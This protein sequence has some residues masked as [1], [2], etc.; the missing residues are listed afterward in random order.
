M[1][2]VSVF[3]AVFGA[4]MGLIAASTQLSLADV[5]L[6]GSFLANKEC[7]AFQS[8][9]KGTNPD[10]AQVESGHSYQLLAKNA[11][12]ATHYRVRIENAS[13]PERWV[14]ADCGLL[15]EENAGSQGSGSPAGTST[16]NQT[17]FVLSLGWEPGFCESHNTKPECASERSD[18]FD[19][20]HFTLHGLW[21]QPRKREYCDVPLELIQADRRGNWQALP[22]VNLSKE[23][24][25]H[26]ALVMPGTR[27]L[28]DRH[29]WIRHGTCYGGD[30]ETYFRQALSLVD[31]I[32]GSAVQSLFAGNIGKE[33]SIGAIKDAFDSA[34]GAG[35]GDRVRL[36]C[37]R[38]GSRQLI[39]EITIGLGAQPGGATSL[40]DLIKASSPTD[41]GCPG[42]IVDA[43]GYQ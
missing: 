22:I 34:F 1:R 4:A 40:G 23:T 35:A 21:P 25:E 31:A 10:G 15:R 19:A 29:E 3:I 13:P 32:N 14:S 7:P 38:D 9:R 43:V 11:P 18:E 26:L 17:Q 8:F 41:P 16:E 42:G 37:K 5:P 6:K 30:V 33:L 27:S 2:T 20:T 24:Q 28:L 39:T 12:V 36:A